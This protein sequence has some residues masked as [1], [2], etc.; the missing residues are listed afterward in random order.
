[1]KSNIDNRNFHITVVQQSEKPRF[2]YTI[3]NRERLR[4]ELIFARD[5]N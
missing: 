5:I 4:F 1:M 3:G 2:A